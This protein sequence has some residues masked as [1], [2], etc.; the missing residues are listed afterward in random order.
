MTESSSSANDRFIRS[1]ILRNVPFVPLATGEGLELGIVS[2]QAP[3]LARA[4]SSLL[5]RSL[6]NAKDTNG[7]HLP[8]AVVERTQRTIISPHGVA[9]IWGTTGHRFALT[10]PAGSGWRELVATILV[11][12][13]HDTVF[14]FT[15]RYN[16]LHHSRLSKDVDLTQA[17]GSNPQERWFDLFAFPALDQYK[18]HGYHHIANFVVAPECRGRGY[19]RSL[20][21]G[22]VEHYRPLLNGRGFWQIGDPPWLAKMQALGFYRRAG[23]EQFFLEQPWAPLPPTRYRGTALTHTEYNQVFGLPKLYEGFVPHPSEHHLL[24]RVPEVIDLSVNPRAKLQ[25]FQAMKEFA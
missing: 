6:D 23:A 17:I 15:G 25:Y 20:M 2:C 8:A 7:G 19:A 22:I 14:F 1:T 13:D 9:N 5:T 11:A 21:D 3:E 18:P 24:D 10:R 16:N 4:V 12:S